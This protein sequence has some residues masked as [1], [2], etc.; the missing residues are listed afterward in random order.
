MGERWGALGTAREALG[1]ARGA[2][3]S[4][5]GAVALGGYIASA[6]FPPYVILIPLLLQASSSDA[7]IVL[8]SDQHRWLHNGWGD[9]IRSGDRYAGLYGLPH[10]TSDPPTVTTPIDHTMYGIPTRSPTL[11]PEWLGGHDPIGG[12]PRWVILITPCYE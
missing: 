4:A 3:G 2:L 9:V 6:Y 7:D 5:C 10:A 11:T 12:S 1:R 8:V